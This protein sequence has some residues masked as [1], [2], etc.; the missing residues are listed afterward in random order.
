MLTRLSRPPV[1]AAVAFVLGV[2]L[3]IAGSALAGNAH[4]HRH[5]E[6]VTQQ[7]T[8]GQVKQLVKKQIA[9]AAPTLSVAHAATAGSAT[10][11]TT[12]ATAANATKVG[13]FLPSDLVRAT[14]A[15]AGDLQFPCD[16]GTVLDNFASATYTDV[17]SK[18]V[19]AP[20]S[21]LLV[22]I[23]NVEAGSDNSPAPPAGAQSTWDSRVT[24]DGTQA[25]GVSDQAV[26]PPITVGCADHDTATVS[27]VVP[28]SAGAHVVKAQIRLRSGNLPLW[29]GYGSVTTL[30]VPFGNSGAQGSLAAPHTPGATSTN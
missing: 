14:T 27:T 16:S 20:T 30:F 23:S 17:V 19:T 11:A 12:A 26:G 18:S 8:K 24:V 9:K 6:V 7:L 29:V 2:S 4:P 25:G 21:G 22:I 28:V 15:T 13:G 10:T 1:A 3:A 5:P